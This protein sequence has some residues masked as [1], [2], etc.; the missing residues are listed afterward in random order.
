[1]SKEKS[2]DIIED[3]IEENVP[4]ETYN[5]R[6]VGIRVK[7]LKG[8]GCP[9][10]DCEIGLVYLRGPHYRL[11]CDECKSHIKFHPKTPQLRAHLEPHGSWYSHC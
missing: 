10:C 9:R 2:F 7:L 5:D 6:G 8:C 11:D 1:M 4:Y 3:V